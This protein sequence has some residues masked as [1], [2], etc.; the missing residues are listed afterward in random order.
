[1]HIPA[2]M[3]TGAQARG[4]CAQKR[5]ARV[6]TRHRAW[7]HACTHTGSS[8]CAHTGHM[9]ICTQAPCMHAHQPT[10]VQV[11]TH[12]T[13][14]HVYTRHPA[15]THTCVHTHTQ[16]LVGLCLYSTPRRAAELRVRRGKAGGKEGKSGAGR[17]SEL[18]VSW[19]VGYLGEP[20]PGSCR[21]ATAQASLPTPLTAPT[22]GL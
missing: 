19:S 13:Q 15:G 8:A 21:A 16:V 22:Q 7:M 3:H 5:H 1:M 17:G 12:R 11:C 2:R 6:H 14:T 18:M 20:S 4:S 9:H 10:C